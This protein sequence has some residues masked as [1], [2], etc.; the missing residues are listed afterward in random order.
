MDRH[1]LAELCARAWGARSQVPLQKFERPDEVERH[2][3]AV[4]L[5]ARDSEGRARL[6]LEHTRVE[7]FPD[8]KI[9]QIAAIELFE[10]LEQKLS[11]LLP[12][13]GHYTLSVWAK[14]TL[15]LRRKVRR[16]RRWTEDWVLATA[17]TLMVASPEI[18]P[19]H[20]SRVTVPDTQL[21]VTLARFP[22]RDGHF[23]LAFFAP[24]E[25]DLAVARALAAKCPKLEDAR[26][27]SP[28]SASLLVLEINDIQLG[29][30]QSLDM[31][32]RSQLAD[33]Q[34]VPEHIW[35]VD[36]S[37]DPPSLLISKEGLKSGEEIAQRFFPNCLRRFS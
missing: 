9:S 11:G 19:R 29:N 17:P 23:G 10:P 21:E 4:D 1:E 12:P 16:I 14:T 36:T 37:D 30:L 33:R 22:R 8:Q 34:E 28:G 32:V 35:L 6:V 24:D 3:K 18:A 5:L 31:A 20:L 15:G 25:L 2:R 26:I 7:S 13:P 27:S